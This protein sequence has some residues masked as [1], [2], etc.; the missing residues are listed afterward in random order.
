M[1]TAPK[2]KTPR[3][4]RPAP[5]LIGV[6]KETGVMDDS[7]GPDVIPA[8][9]FEGPSRTSMSLEEIACVEGMLVDWDLK[10]IE[11]GVGCIACCRLFTESVI[12]RRPNGSIC[13]ACANI[14]SK[15][16]PVKPSDRIGNPEITLL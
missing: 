12:R 7:A 16:I 6:K 9:A 5:K 4:K 13:R 14:C 1:S 3:S 11:N 15:M 2:V 10:H 8:L